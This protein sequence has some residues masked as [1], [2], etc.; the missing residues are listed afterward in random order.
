M[1]K[2]R[3]FLCSI[4]SIVFLAG[5]ALQRKFE[6]ISNTFLEGAPSES[7][8]SRVP[9][10]HAWATTTPSANNITAIYVLPVRTD[11]LDPDSWLDSSSLSITSAADFQAEVQ[12]L[13]LFFHERLTE[14]LERAYAN[15][16]RFQIVAKPEPTAVNL[17]LALTEVVFSRPATNLAVMAAP[18]PG[19]GAALSMMTAPVVAFAARFTSPDGHELW[20]TVADRREPPFRPVDLNKFTVASSA[21][22]VVSQWARE[23]AE[24][25][26]FDRLKPVER[27]PWFSLLPW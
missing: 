12:A 6:P 5:C 8:I 25:I 4:A 22:D 10:K 21:R 1:H 27:S 24:A 19:A 13:A 20:G 23:L 3:F 11:K 2:S 7:T 18:V 17:E 26:E 16:N 14:E 15:T 9:F